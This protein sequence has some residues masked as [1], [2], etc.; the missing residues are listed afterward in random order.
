MILRSTNLTC[1]Y[2]WW[3][4]WKVRDVFRLQD[5]LHVMTDG[6]AVILVSS[7]GALKCVG[8]VILV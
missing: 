3:L 8:R 6:T 2:V 4:W 7:F 1:I 5:H